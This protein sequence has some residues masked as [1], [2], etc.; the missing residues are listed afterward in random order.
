M[1]KHSLPHTGWECVYHIVWIPKCRRK[2]LHGETRREVGEILGALAERMG[3][4][5]MVEGSAC[6]DHIRIC[7]RIAPRLSVS[8]VVGKLKGKSAI[9]LHGRHPEWRRAAGRDRTLWARG[10][11]V[12]TVGLNE[13][14][15]RRCIRNQEDGSRIE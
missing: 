12:S 15:I 14:V 6:P 13:S 4:V 2:V 9:I 7:L 3:G 1:D 11:C 10:H 8:N 5:E